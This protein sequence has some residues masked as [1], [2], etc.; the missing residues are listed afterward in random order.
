V[1]KKEIWKDIPGYEGLFQ[2]SSKGRIKSLKRMVIR[3]YKNHPRTVPEKIRT[4]SLDKFGYYHIALSKE[5]KRKNYF[6][7]RLIALT[8][9][10][11]PNNLPQVN[12]I[13]GNKKNCCI[14]NLEW[15]NQSENLKHAYRIGLQ[16][17]SGGA[18][19]YKPVAQY[20]LDGELICKYKSIT[21]AM[22]ATG[23]GSISACVN[24]KKKYKT[25]K[26]Y[27]WKKI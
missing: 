2:A 9:I 27:I 3:G 5:N 19:K 23:A 17:P 4:L 16:K 12:H 20:S 18:V 22:K 1:S 7:H 6:V 25:S 21:E 15:V 8:F 13:D 14:E 24:N 11:N 26:G 10:K